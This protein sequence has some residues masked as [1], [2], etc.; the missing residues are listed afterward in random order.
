MTDSLIQYF[1]VAEKFGQQMSYWIGDGLE[2]ILQVRLE[3]IHPNFDPPWRR[4]LTYF[5]IPTTYLRSRTL[6]GGRYE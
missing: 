6:D 3:T 5:S 4:M 2:V 1:D